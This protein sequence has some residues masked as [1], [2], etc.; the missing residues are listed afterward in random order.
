MLQ[1][2]YFYYKFDMICFILVNNLDIV[3]VYIYFIYCIY[4]LRLFSATLRRLI[5]SS[6]GKILILQLRSARQKISKKRLG[7]T[8]R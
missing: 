1:L 6:K 5:R 8:I 4:H 2:H 3:K 7:K